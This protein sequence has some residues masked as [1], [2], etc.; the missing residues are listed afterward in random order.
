MKIRFATVCLV[1]NGRTATHIHWDAVHMRQ[2]VENY[3]KFHDFTMNV[4][5]VITRK[6]TSQ[7]LT[8]RYSLNFT[9]SP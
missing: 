1:L 7:L 6:I 3:Y 2:Q 4:V 5:C 8:F 9:F